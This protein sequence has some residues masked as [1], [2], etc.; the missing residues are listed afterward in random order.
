MLNDLSNGTYIVFARK[1]DDP[2]AT[3]RFALI[4]TIFVNS[5]LI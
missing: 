3:F 2:S 1:L 5:S 4:S